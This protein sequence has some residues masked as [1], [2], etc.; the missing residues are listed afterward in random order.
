M[1]PSDWPRSFTGVLT[2]PSG[3]A[4]FS[5]GPVSAS[6]PAPLTPPVRS[7]SLACLP[8]ALCYPHQIPHHPAL[9]TSRSDSNQGD[10]A[11]RLSLSKKS[12][13]V[14]GESSFGT[15]LKAF[16]SAV[17]GGGG[18]GR[19]RLG[20]LGVRVG[21]TEWVYGRVGIFSSILVF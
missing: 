17:G 21:R 7:P 12:Q 15:A 1:A 2:E 20:T 16:A 13:G 19:R 6:A 9:R 8:I 5:G 11:K 18:S 3:M 4:Q 10:H 14:R